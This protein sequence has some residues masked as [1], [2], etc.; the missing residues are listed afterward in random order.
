MQVDVVYVTSL[1]RSFFGKGKMALVSPIH[2]LSTEIAYV[3]KSLILGALFGEALGHP[4]PTPLRDRFA[5]ALQVCLYGIA[6]AP[7]ELRISPPG[8]DPK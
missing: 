3:L 2:R 5:L 7:P 8:T 1:Y 4:S 6:G